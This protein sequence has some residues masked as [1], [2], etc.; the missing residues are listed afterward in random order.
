MSPSNLPQ[1]ARTAAGRVTGQ[2]RHLAVLSHLAGYEA[3]IT[4]SSVA[5]Y[6]AQYEAGHWDYLSDTD[7]AVRYSVLIGYAAQLPHRTILDVGCGAGILRARMEHLDFEHY[8][9]VDP[10]PGAIKQA[11]RLADHRT[12]FIVGDAFQPSLEPFDLVVCNEVLYSVPEPRRQLDRIRDLVREGG[13]LLTSNLRHPGDVGLYR[14]LSERFETV[15]DVAISNRTARGRR[16]RRI[17]VYRRP[18]ERYYDR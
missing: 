17:S 5:A 3:A 16:R 9:G 2:L 15:D 10:V 12:S 7:Q 11:G 13:H 14:L 4:P 1:R 8:M 6:A 18:A